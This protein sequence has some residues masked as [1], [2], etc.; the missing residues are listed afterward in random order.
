MYP[1]GVGWLW[2]LGLVN[3]IWL[4]GLTLIFWQNRIFLQK[5]VPS[6]GRLLK[7]KLEEVLE[8]FES[9]EGLKKTNLNNIQRVSL[10]RYNPY[11]DT[12]GDQSFSIALLDG[13]G[14]G[15]VLTSLH[16]RAGTRIFA[17]PVKGGRQDRFELSKEEQEV[18]SKALK[19]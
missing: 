2:V 15:L 18:V 1:D 6:K 16:S 17:K 5:L 4:F 7:D 3:I 9:L 14:N 8:G 19:F 10:K 13:L 11:Q 12:G